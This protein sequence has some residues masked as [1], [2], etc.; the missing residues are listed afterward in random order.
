M[1]KNVVVLMSTYN[2]ERYL[3]EQIDSILNQEGVKVKLIV[4]DDGSIDRTKEILDMYKRRGLLIWYK[5]E[6][7]KPARSFMYLL[8]N[9]PECEYYAF[10]DQDDYWMP[11]KLYIAISKLKDYSDIPALYFSQTQL[12]DEFLQPIY[13]KKITPKCN[14]AES[15]LETLATGCTFLFNNKLRQFVSIYNPNYLFMHDYWLYRLCTAID[16]KL[17]FDQEPH[18]YYR[19]HENNVVGLR[20]NTWL[21]LQQKIQRFLTRER[22]R[23]KTSEELL[24]GYA[25]YIDK[26][27]SEF[28]NLSHEYCKSFGSGIRLI[29]NPFIKGQ[30]LLTSNFSA[31]LAIL[32][33]IY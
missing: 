27:K 5:G 28:L 7:L 3:I 9:S 30:Y 12:V 20:Q 13:T 19:Q 14:F 26:E 24:R 15:V 25:S 6:N 2:G 21:G 22:Q 10:A 8:E 17:I 18:I 16:G 33:K 31:K 1:M 11:D 32:L 4:R 23:S 29:L